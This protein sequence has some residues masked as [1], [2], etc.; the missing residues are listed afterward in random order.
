MMG[1]AVL[2]CD[3]EWVVEIQLY[4]VATCTAKRAF[5]TNNGMPYRPG[6]NRTWRM[7]HGIILFLCLHPPPPY[8]QT[9]VGFLSVAW[10]SFMFYKLLN[11]FLL[12]CVDMFTDL[13]TVFRWSWAS[14]DYDISLLNLLSGRACVRE[15]GLNNVRTSGEAELLSRSTHM[16]LLRFDHLKGHT[17]HL[18][19]AMPQNWQFNELK[20]SEGMDIIMLMPDH[21]IC[22]AR[23]N[24]SL[25]T[26][27]LIIDTSF[28][29]QEFGTFETWCPFPS[30]A[31]FYKQYLLHYKS[32]LPILDRLYPP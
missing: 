2:E 11:T 29:C 6:G 25:C 22:A 13:R 26:W 17:I 24:S 12:L 9:L 1:M 27:G 4:L 31:C 14:K 8:T 21:L 7:F 28:L 32:C 23:F 30:S 20:P 16:C 19:M 5:H 10:L 3:A 15:G 18:A